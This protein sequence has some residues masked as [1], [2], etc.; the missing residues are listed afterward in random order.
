MSCDP[1][2]CFCVPCRL[3]TKEN[4]EKAIE[5]LNGSTLSDSPE[6]L[7]VKF[8]DSSSNKKRQH[9][10]GGA[11]RT[12]SSNST[13]VVTVPSPFSPPS[14]PLSLSPPLPCRSL[15]RHGRCK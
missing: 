14:P 15:E 12:S 5:M 1:L 13:S 6:P 4:C 10:P 7:M 11:A 8:A 9:G 2:A 3:D